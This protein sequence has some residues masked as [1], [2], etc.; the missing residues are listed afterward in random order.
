MR[1]MILGSGYVGLVSGICFAEFGFNVVSV[2]TDVEKIHSLQK[3]KLPIYEPGLEQLLQKN[4][5]QNIIFSND[6]QAHASNV[7]IIFLAIGTPSAANGAVDLSY[8]YQ[9]ARDLAPLLE[10]YT[11]IVIKSTVPP[12]TC[13]LVKQEILRV[14]PNAKFDI[15]SNPEFLREGVAVRDFMQPDRI[16]IGLD[17]AFNREIMAKLYKPLHLQNVPIVYTSLET[18]E[19]IKYAS[20]ALLATKIAFINEMADVCE[21]VGADVQV[22]AHAVGLDQRIGPQFLQ[23]GPGFGGS[24]FPKDTLGLQNFAHSVGAPAKIIDAVINANNV[25]KTNCVT[26]VLSACNGSVDGKEIAVLGVAFKANTDDIRESPALE[27]IS[28]L[29]A[30]GAHVRL[31]DPAAMANARAY[32]GERDNLRYSATL[33]ECLCNAHVA[34][35]L[36]E[37]NEFKTLNLAEVAGL[38]CCYDEHIP[39]TLIDLRNLYN[40]NDFA[41]LNLRY[42]S[43]GRPIVQPHLQSA[44]ADIHELP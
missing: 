2:D 28:G 14:N 37:W 21:K 42:V 20:N 6:L 41:D 33:K 36:T 35:I 11:P 3:G 26:K 27:I 29:L 43:L 39:R 23:P 10:K 18:A 12:G 13:S 8:I 1:I 7:D 30:N 22:L 38:L 17:N 24:C 19:L 15:V 40:G 31:Y 9:A 32:F 25:R 5:G 34:L 4:L 16:V 44:K